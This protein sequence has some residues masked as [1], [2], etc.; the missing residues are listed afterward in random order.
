MLHDELTQQISTVF[1]KR[2][3]ILPMTEGLA[4]AIRQATDNEAI[5][6]TFLYAFMP[7]LDIASYPVDLFMQITKQALYV[8]EKNLFE[9]KILD[10][11]F[12]NFVLQGRINNENLE[13]NRVFFIVFIVPYR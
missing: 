1:G 6:L 4:A 13:F 8:R 5:C 2:F 3:S 10:E 12:L 7:V 9:E 11:V